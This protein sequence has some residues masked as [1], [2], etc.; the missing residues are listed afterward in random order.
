[1]FTGR[2]PL[3]WLQLTF[4]K[5]RLF[6][7]LLGV[8]FANVM[9]FMQLGFLAALYD[10]ATQIH[11]RMACDLV[12]MNPGSE[13]MFRMASFSRRQ[14]YRAAGHPQVDRVCPVYIGIS[15][16]KNPWTG[17]N[18]TI[19]VFGMSPQDKLVDLPGFDKAAM[20]QLVLSDTCLFDELSR[21]EFGPVATAFRAGD[22]IEAEVNNHRV[23][24]RGLVQVGA[25]FAADGNVVT[26]DA[27]FLRMFTTRSAG[28]ID[29]GCVTLKP[30]SDVRQVQKDLQT[31]L[32]SY[33][34]VFTRDEFVAFE[35]KY[36]Q[37]NAPIGFIF[38]AGTILGFVIGF[39]IVYQIL[40]TDVAN[41]LSQYATLKAIGYSD[42]YLVKVV[43]EESL[44]LSILGYFPGMAITLVLYHMAHNATHLPIEMNIM[45]AA[46]V[47]GLTT[48]MCFFSGLVAVRKLRAADPAEVF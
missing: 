32:G 40:Y 39:V 1:M 15:Q 9:M 43:L 8:S 21:Q 14:L 37:D 22:A 13:A 31:E 12:L 11:R 10:S 19:L 46:M 42:W 24:V 23:K 34:K 7:A 27:N 48:L 47:F 28:A 38:T 5:T 36:W 41:H 35:K 2:I 20:N 29:I 16:W 6:V 17:K 25:S 26:S 44:I 4:G 3:A 18:R 33:M 30:G 45:R